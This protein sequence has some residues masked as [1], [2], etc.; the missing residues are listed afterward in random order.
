MA[1]LGWPK[2]SPL[3]NTNTHT[4]SVSVKHILLTPFLIREC[5]KGVMCNGVKGKRGGVGV[6]GE[7]DTEL[8]WVVSH[9]QHW[10]NVVSKQWCTWFISN[11][12]APLCFGNLN[13]LCNDIFHNAVCQWQTVAVCFL[14]FCLHH[15]LKSF[16]DITDQG[17]LLFYLLFFYCQPR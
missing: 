8:I 1:P 12:V 9:C 13:F 5:M 14:L 7:L 16:L 15:V 3:L 11:M 2:V 6:E 4:H 10:R 17:L